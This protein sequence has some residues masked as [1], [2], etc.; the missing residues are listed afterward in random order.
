[1]T[2]SNAEKIACFTL[3]MY[4]VP[5]TNFKMLISAFPLAYT[6]AHDGTGQVSGTAR[7]ADRRYVLCATTA[8]LPFSA[9]PSSHH[10]WSSLCI[11]PP[12]RANLAIRSAG[13]AT[14]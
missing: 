9:R 5:Q 13:L 6:I 11:C 12:Y 1:M 7:R 10:F 4:E 3:L 14:H 8:A 2:G